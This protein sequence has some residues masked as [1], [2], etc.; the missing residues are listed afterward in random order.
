LHRKQPTV[1]ETCFGNLNKLRV[2]RPGCQPIA[3]TG[4]PPVIHNKES[5]FCV[6]SGLR[7]GQS[8]RT[9]LL[10][11]PH[12]ITRQL[13][14]H[15]TERIFQ[16]D[17]IR[18][19]CQNSAQ[20]DAE[21]IPLIKD[22]VGGSAKNAKSLRGTLSPNRTP[23]PGLNYQENLYLFVRCRTLTRVSKS[24]RLAT[25]CSRRVHLYQTDYGSANKKFR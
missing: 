19:Q 5:G 1:L 16:I 22:H 10:L 14:A 2:H 6:G 15:A 18:N 12:S 25:H 3:S 7:P 11:L 23:W 17:F 9:R 24:I 4:F 8:R 13:F 20:A 21:D